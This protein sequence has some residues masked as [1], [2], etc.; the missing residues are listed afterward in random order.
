MLKIQRTEKECIVVIRVCFYFCTP[1]LLLWAFS[2]SWC[3]ALFFHFF[4]FV[5]LYNTEQQQ[6]TPFL[7]SPPFNSIRNRI[8]V[9]RFQ[10][11]IVI[12]SWTLK[13]ETKH[14]KI[15]NRQLA[16]QFKPLYRGGERMKDYQWLYFLCNVK[17]SISR[18]S[19]SLDG[20]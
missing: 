13:A 9:F 6:P 17:I 5:S 16:N 1:K 4:G 12:Q 3:A 20:S 19:F 15:F 11:C 2:T 8:F 7:F 14:V 10:H 18:F